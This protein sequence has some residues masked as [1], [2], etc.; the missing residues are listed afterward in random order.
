MPSNRNTTK[1]GASV[2]RESQYGRTPLYSAIIYGHQDVEDYLRAQGAR[3]NEWDLEAF[4]ILGISVDEN[5]PT[6]AP[7]ALKPAHP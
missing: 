2:A 6:A 3:L 5:P 1:L 4:R 7:D